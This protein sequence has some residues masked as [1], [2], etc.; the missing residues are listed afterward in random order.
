MKRIFILDDMQERHD[1]YRE[2]FPD[3]EIVSTFDAKEAIASLSNDLDYNLICLDHDLGLRIFVDTND[4]NTGSAVAKFL[5]DKE[6]KCPIIIHSLNYWGA[7][8]MM[9][10]LPKAKYMPFF[11]NKE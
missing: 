8:N 6:I 7:K 10:Y 5:A 3:A 1:A 2:K 4:E 11:F 9:G